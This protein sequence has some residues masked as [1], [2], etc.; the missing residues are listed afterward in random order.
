MRKIYIVTLIIAMMLIMGCN[1]GKKTEPKRED[2]EKQPYRTERMLYASEQKSCSCVIDTEVID[3]MTELI[4]ED[5]NKASMFYNIL[6]K[7]G[8][9]LI[10][11]KN[12][13]VACY[14]SET[15]CGFIPVI[16]MEGEYKGRRAYVPPNRLGEI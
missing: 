11:R 15:Y 10:V 2:I 8:E 6:V 12:T 13:K 9:I 5:K 1:S 4:E 3:I 14:Y 7:K 16:F